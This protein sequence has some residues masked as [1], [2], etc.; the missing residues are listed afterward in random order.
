MDWIISLQFVLIV[1]DS[2]PSRG[3]PRGTAPPEGPSAP[4]LR[5]GR[6]TD[7]QARDP[8]PAG[9]HRGPITS[10]DGAFLPSGHRRILI[11]FR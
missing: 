6:F 4:L 9:S 8:L 5:P 11:Q 2:G 7:L 1:W 10:H 3:L